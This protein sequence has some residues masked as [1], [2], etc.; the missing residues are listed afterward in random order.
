VHCLIVD[1]NDERHCQ[2]SPHHQKII[3][4]SFVTMFR[5][6]AAV[7]SL[8][9]LAAAAA[10]PTF[11]RTPTT[12]V[13]AASTLARGGGGQEYESLSAPAPGSPFHYAFPVHNLEAAKSFYGSV[14]GCQEGRSSE[15]VRTIIYTVRGKYNK[16]GRRTRSINERM[17][18]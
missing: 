12:A 14:L 1:I 5:L 10:R 18:E 2:L 11:S 13:L 3:I 17:N 6:V 9:P 15:K 8:T 7:A 4:H 16:Y